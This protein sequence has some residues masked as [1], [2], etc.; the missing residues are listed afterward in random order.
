MPSIRL[1]TKIE[2]WVRPVLAVVLL[3]D[4]LQPART[5]ARIEWIV[6]RGIRQQDAFE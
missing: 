3:L 1:K 4:R 2:W 5:E 6:D